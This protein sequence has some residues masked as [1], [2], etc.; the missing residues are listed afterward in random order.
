MGAPM[1]RNLAAA[2][3]AVTDFDLTPEGVVIHAVHA[4]TKD[5]PID[6]KGYR[7]AH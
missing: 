1:A 5:Y 6:L 3:H 4:W 2:G 7:S